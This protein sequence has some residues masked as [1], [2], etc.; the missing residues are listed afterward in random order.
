M[1]D[2]DF[3]WIKLLKLNYRKSESCRMHWN[4][5]NHD[6]F[7][8]RKLLKLKYRKGDQ[9]IHVFCKIDSS[10]KLC[11]PLYFVEISWL[12]EKYS[13]IMKISLKANEWRRNCVHKTF[14][15][16]I[17]KRE[18]NNE[19]ILQNLLPPEIKSPLFN[20]KKF[21][22]SEKGTRETEKMNWNLMN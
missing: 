3:W 11:P 22:G 6:E 18:P 5:L 13:L 10:Q 21:Q 15:I 7:V 8:S 20:L 16:E 9:I 14:R 12:W 17:Q 2:K 19:G 4:T 1:R